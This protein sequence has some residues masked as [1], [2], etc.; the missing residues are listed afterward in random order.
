[1]KKYLLILPVVIG[2]FLA[3]PAKAT[4]FLMGDFSGSNVQPVQD[5]K[6]SF[7]STYVTTQFNGVHELYLNFYD[8]SNVLVASSSIESISNCSTSC[9]VSFDFNVEPVLDKYK[10]YHVEYVQVSGGSI[11]LVTYYQLLYTLPV[12]GDLNLALAYPVSSS[13]ITSDFASWAYSLA[14]T[15]DNMGGGIEIHWG[16][17]PSNLTH[18]DSTHFIEVYHLASYYKYLP[19]RD[20]LESNTTYY[21]KVLDVISNVSSTYTFATGQLTSMFYNDP[22]LFPD[23]PT[24]TIMDLNSTS[25]PFYVDCSG[26]GGGGL[27]SSSTVNVLACYGQKV[28]YSVVGFLVVPPEF[29]SNFMNSSLNS[30]KTVFP[31]SMVYGS[32]NSIENAVSAT[33]TVDYDNLKIDMPQIGISTNILSDDMIAGW[34][35]TDSCDATCA[36]AKQENYFDIMRAIIWVGV[37]FKI[38]LLVI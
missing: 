34:L 30:L 22:L 35:T 17:N 11:T 24:S 25:S 18:V 10:T 16:T 8:A 12:A 37:G 1:M 14:P 31:F 19:K 15:L 7:I 32:V 2:L 27:F 23:M 33:S 13:T 29:I 5:G 6:A 21:V 3:S 28:L 36:T 20:R 26:T 38:L 4:T 9:P